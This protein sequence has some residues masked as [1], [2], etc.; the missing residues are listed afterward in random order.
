MK[1]SYLLIGMPWDKLPALETNPAYLPFDQSLVEAGNDDCLFD[2]P[3]RRR[4]IRLSALL[5]CNTK[6][7]VDAAVSALHKCKNIYILLDYFP[8]SGNPTILSFFRF[9]CLQIAQ[10]ISGTFPRANIAFM[11]SPDVLLLSAPKRLTL[12]WLI[13]MAERYV[14]IVSKSKFAFDDSG[15]PLIPSECYAK[16]IPNDMID[17]PHRRSRL[18]ANPA[19]TA[20]CFF[21]GDSGIY[22]RLERLSYDIDEYRRYAA[23]VMPDVTVTS[24]MDLPW[25]AFIMLLNQLYIAA[26]ASEGVKIIAN[27]R[28][29]S[30]ESRRFLKTIPKGILCA[31]GSLGCDNLNRPYDYAFA[32]K[33]L[34]L[35]PSALLIYGKK[36]S[37]ANEQLAT[38][39]ITV[40]SYPDSHAR[41][42]KNN[43]ARATCKCDFAA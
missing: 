5:S 34:K 37:I 10:Y 42:K 43:P 25:Q 33:I 18:I 12:P 8:T 2:L 24:D 38:M 31:S 26:V 9:R 29:G 35:R 36:D 6:K 17:Y 4:F 41:A 19:S 16:R 1:A 23:V 20:I 14:S 13:Q 11:A 21:M 32:E 27:T 3:L 22:P 7:E 28:C 30:P 39:G 15:F 40:I